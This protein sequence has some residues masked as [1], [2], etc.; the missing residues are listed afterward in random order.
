METER[1]MAQ[2]Q[3]AEANRRLDDADRRAEE[4]QRDARELLAKQIQLSERL[5]G[6]TVSSGEELAR[7]HPRDL[8]RMADRLERELPE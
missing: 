7:M 2:E 8:R 1:R 3:L 4:A 5:L 6:R